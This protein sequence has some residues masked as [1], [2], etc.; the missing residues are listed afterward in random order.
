MLKQLIQSQC[1]K[2]D[3]KSFSAQV[4]SRLDGVDNRIATQDNNISTL[5][6]RM[7]DCEKATASAHYQLELDK[8]RQLK[9]NI[10]I[11]GIPKTNG[12]KLV[13][14]VLKLLSKVG[15]QLTTANVMNCYRIKGN[16]NHI[17]IVKFSDFEIK[18][19]ILANKSKKKGNAW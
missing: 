9:N 14:M 19:Q 5:V 4:S 18:Q 17:I 15:C 3:F 16:G 10:S 13:D 8:Q 11:I 1:T 12:E 6:K 2:D 7:D